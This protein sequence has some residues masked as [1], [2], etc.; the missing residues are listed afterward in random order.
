[1][2]DIQ[3]INRNTEIAPNLSYAPANHVVKSMRPNF[4]DST[5]I[6]LYAQPSS[7]PHLVITQTCL[8]CIQLSNS[9]LYNT[10]KC[11]KDNA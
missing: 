8:W 7:S 10:D 2:G 1:M 4:P 9:S 3:R 6:T 11:I 5:T